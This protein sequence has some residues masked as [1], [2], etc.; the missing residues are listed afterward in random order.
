ML[1]TKGSTFKRRYRRSL[2]KSKIIRRLEVCICCSFFLT[3][4][5]LL[6]SINMNQRLLSSCL[7]H[8]KCLIR[9]V[10]VI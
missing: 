3:Y 7:K 5:S 6:R 9:K 4:L 2:S 10:T 1:A 8:F